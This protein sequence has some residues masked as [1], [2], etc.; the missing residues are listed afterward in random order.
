[1][2]VVRVLTD[3]DGR[4][5]DTLTRSDAIPGKCLGVKKT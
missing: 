2:S 4:E 1:V 5:G 3:R